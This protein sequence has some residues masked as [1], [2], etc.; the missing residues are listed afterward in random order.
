[1]R[2]IPNLMTLAAV[3][4]L[5]F[6][7]NTSAFAQNMATES[8]YSNVFPWVEADKTDFFSMTRC[9]Y[10]NEYVF[11][12]IKGSKDLDM[13]DHIRTIHP[14]VYMEEGYGSSASGGT[15]EGGASGSSQNNGMTPNSEL[16]V[17]LVGYA[18]VNIGVCP[19]IEWIEDD[20]KRYVDVDDDGFAP[21]SAIAGYIYSRYDTRNVDIQTAI[22][23]NYPFLIFARPACDNGRYII[24]S[25]VSQLD[26]Y[27]EIYYD[28]VFVFY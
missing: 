23:R 3:L 4:L 25:G 7:A 20:F 1:M 6:V 2:Y 17:P 14:E 5:T 11:S 8:M 24:I 28:Y 19:D 12:T 9:K 27:G 21:V 16:S 26:V 13:E 15:P 22:N 18:L 10:C